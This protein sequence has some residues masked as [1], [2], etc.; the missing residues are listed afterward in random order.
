MWLFN[1]SIILSF[2]LLLN[3]LNFCYSRCI[4]LYY[5]SWH[6][7]KHQLQYQLQCQ[8]AQHPMYRLWYHQ[9]IIH[10]HH[11]KYQAI[12]SIPSISS[13]MRASNAPIMMP[14]ATYASSHA[15]SSIPSMIPR[16][17]PYNYHTHTPTM[18]SSV[19]P[20]QIPKCQVTNSPFA[21]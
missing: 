15:P 12:R 11:V 19:N 1:H 4:Q 2:V 14:T 6:H 20:S 5:Q 16:S 13:V 17:N 3:I 8:P 18:K 7:F 10:S 21:K 9:I